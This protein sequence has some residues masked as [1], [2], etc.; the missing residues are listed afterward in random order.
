MSV[1]TETKAIAVAMKTKRALAGFGTCDS[2]VDVASPPRVDV[3][4]PKRPP[5][6]ATA[7]VEPTKAPSPPP[8]A[9]WAACSTADAGAGTVLGG[10]GHAPETA[11]LPNAAAAFSAP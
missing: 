3:T 1:A 7:G 8:E 10:G 2:S 9:K 5:A 11:A 6:T 4:G